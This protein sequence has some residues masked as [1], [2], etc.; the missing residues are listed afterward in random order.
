MEHNNAIEYRIR[1]TYNKQTTDNIFF[2]DLLLSGVTGLA[3]HAEDQQSGVVT[4]CV[5]LWAQ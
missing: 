5:Q 4:A 1:L 2:S 3:K